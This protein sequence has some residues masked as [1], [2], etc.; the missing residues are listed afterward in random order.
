MPD[1]SVS[2]QYATEGFPKAVVSLGSAG[3]GAVPK[4][5]TDCHFH[6][7][8]DFVVHSTRRRGCGNV[9]NPTFTRTALSGSPVHSIGGFVV[10]RLVT[11]K[12]VIQLKITLQT[13]T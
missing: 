11:P 6:S 13:R 7:P 5:S 10:Q 3:F 2:I 1:D 12:S 9:G 8:L 4:L